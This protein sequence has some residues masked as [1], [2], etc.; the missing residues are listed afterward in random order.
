MI[1]LIHQARDEMTHK[2]VAN[3]RKKKGSSMTKFQKIR[4]KKMGAEYGSGLVINVLFTL[5]TINLHG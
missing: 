4:F 2:A 1:F 5:F 3:L